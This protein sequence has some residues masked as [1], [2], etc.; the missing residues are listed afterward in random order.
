[1][2]QASDINNIIRSDAKNLLGLDNI[3]KIDFDLIERCHQA[4]ERERSERERKRKQ[5]EQRKQESLT[6]IK[7]IKEYPDGYSIVELLPSPV[8]DEN[9]K[10]LHHTS[11]KFESDEMGHCVGRGGYNKYIGKEGWH[12]Y[13]LRG[14]DENGVM[15][16]HCT[17]SIENG[18]LEQIK[19]NSNGAVKNRYIPDVRDFVKS[20]NMPIPESEKSGIGYIR[21][22]NKREVD[23][24]DLKENIHI[25][26]R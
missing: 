12:F 15:I 4:Y 26:F 14:P 2:T 25:Q 3:E 7:V 17:I 18:R 6:G 10:I 5:I 24:F 9:G 22:I 11:L 1:M 23:L 16:P 13:S 19:G 8:Y 21:D 20:L